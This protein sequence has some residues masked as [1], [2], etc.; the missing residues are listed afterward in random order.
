MKELE[1]IKAIFLASD[2]DAEDYPGTGTTV[3]DKTGNGYNATLVGTINHSTNVLNY[4]PS[5]T[6]D[7][8]Y[9]DVSALQ[10]LTTPDRWTID[11]VIRLDSTAGTTYFHS[12]A[13]TAQNNQYIVQKTTAVFPYNETQQSGGNLTFSAGET[14]LLTIVHEGT[15][16]KYYKNGVLVSSWTAASDI[17]QTEGWTINQEQD[18]V[19]GGFDSTQC[20]D[21]GMYA[22]RLYDKALTAAEVK[23]NYDAVKT[24]Y[25]I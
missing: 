10:A 11:S 20:T 17:R 1:K 3:T 2:I 16:Q 9:F 21:M 22:V 24:R 12:M 6:T 19:L 8:L 15:S 7:Y 14:F 4:N 25:G 23:Q 5:Q 13:T 18:S